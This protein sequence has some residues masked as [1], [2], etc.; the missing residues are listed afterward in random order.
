MSGLIRNFTST[1]G[2]NPMAVGDLSSVKPIA[3]ADV[4][5]V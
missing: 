2:I 5:L 4:S 3:E 1:P